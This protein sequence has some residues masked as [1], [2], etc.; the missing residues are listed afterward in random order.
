LRTRRRTAGTQRPD[1]LYADR[2]YDHDKYRKQVREAG[3]KPVIAR[4]GE[5]HDS[6]L[7]VY[8][9]V[10]EQGFA[11]LH[12]FR[13][14]RRGGGA[15]SPGQRGAGDGQ[16]AARLLQYRRGGR[17]TRLG[18]DGRIRI[19]PPSTWPIIAGPDDSPGGSP[20]GGSAA[21]ILWIL[22]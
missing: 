18:D 14:G 7:G 13:R 19:V 22:I 17:R 20:A 12:W 2:G 9:W 11:L 4:R 8:R 6:G 1:A 21:E 15:L 3:I 16:K 10:V 5:Q